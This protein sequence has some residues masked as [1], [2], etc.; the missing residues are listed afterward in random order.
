M[1]SHFRIHSL[2]SGD[3]LQRPFNL[4]TRTSLGS[5]SSW[6]NPRGHGK[7]ANSTQTASVFRIESGSVALWGSTS[8]AASLCPPPLVTN[9]CS[10]KRDTRDCSCWITKKMQSAGT[11]QQLRYHSCNPSP[12]RRAQPKMS[13]IHIL[14]RCRV[15]PALCV[16]LCSCIACLSPQS[17]VQQQMAWKFQIVTVQD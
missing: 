10:Y 16:F 17:K 7:F 12:A 15:T 3:N 5:G 4:Q 14:K 11:T 1:L 2:C 8:A 6:K 9:D 13:P